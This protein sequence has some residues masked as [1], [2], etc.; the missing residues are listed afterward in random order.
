MSSPA[1]RVVVVGSVN[2]D[3]VVASDRLPAPGET[4]LGGTFRRFHGGKGGNAATAA[5]RLGARTLLVAA[6]GDDDLGADARA[7][8]ANT[9]VALD[10]LA[11][12]EG[13]PTGVA[14][15]LVDAAGE[16]LI[17]VAP[18]ANAQLTPAQ[19]QAAFSRLGP[20]PGDVVLVGNEIP[21]RT[22]R[23]ALELGHAAGA[24]TVFNPA[25][26][27]GV[28][29]AMLAA[30]DILTPNRVELA[31][32]AGAEA[33]ADDVAALARRL[34]APRGEGAVGVRDAV[35]VSLGRVGALLVRAE[36]QRELPAPAVEAVDA[37]GAGDALNGALAA[38]LVRGRSLEDAAREAVIAA[39]LSVTRP[40]AREGMP[41]REELDRALA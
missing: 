2:V 17:S 8:L 24:T 10:V 4:V 21:A 20:Q 36:A 28:D 41:T 5:A 19:V 31:R 1:G 16:N 6:V 7:A 29:D 3:L 30:T 22:A 32:L 14:L 23:A 39:S 12:I 26:A 27:D 9:R 33:P 34:M 38:A 37:T 35:L 13:V 11:T 25:P 18:G 15:I 40:G